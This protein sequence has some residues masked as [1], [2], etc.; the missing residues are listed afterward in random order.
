MQKFKKFS[1]GL[2]IIALVLNLTGPITAYAAAVNTATNI[3]VTPG[4]QYTTF[5]GVPVY[6]LHVTNAGDAPDSITSLTPTPLGNVDDTTISLHFYNDINNNGFADQGDTNLGASAAFASDNTKQ[7]FNIDDVVVPASGSASILITADGLTVG[8]AQIFNLSFALGTDILM[9]TVAINNTGAFP[10]Q[11]MDPLTASNTAPSLTIDDGLND[12]APKTAVASET[13][14]VVKQLSF[15]AL[16][17]SDS[18]VSLAITPS[19]SVNDATQIL[20]TKFYIDSGTT[21]GVVDVSDI[22]LSKTPTTYTADNTQTIFTFSSPF[23]IATGSTVNILYTY[24]LGAGVSGGETLTATLVGTGSTVAGS[25][26]VVTTNSSIVS[27]TITISA[28][29]PTLAQPTAVAS[30]T[31]KASSSAKVIGAFSVTETGGIIDT[32][33][34]FTIENKAALTAVSSDIASVSI[35]SDGGTLGVIDGGDALAC[36]ESTTNTTTDFDA[37]ASTITFTCSSP[38]SIGANSTNNYLAV[39][40]TTVGATNGRTI[41]A[42]VNAH[43]VTAF[44]WA[45]A[46]LQTTN[47]ITIDSV[48]PTVLIESDTPTLNKYQVANLSF[49]LSESSIDFA[50]GDITIVGGVLSDFA[51]SGTSYTAIFTPTDESTTTGTVDVSTLK[52]TDAAANDNTAATQLSM[53]IDTVAPTLVIE[54]DEPGVANIAGGDVVYTFTFSEAVTGLTI[55]DITISGGTKGVFTAVSGTVYTLVVTPNSSSTTNITVDVA[56]AV[57]IDAAGND[58]SAATQSVQ[59]VDTTITSPT[60][61]SSGGGG[62]SYSPT[63]L[64]LISILKVP[65]SLSLPSGTNYVTYYYTVWNKTS[66]QT[67]TNVSVI[68]DI[69]NKLTLVSGDSNVNEKLDPLEKWKYSCTTALSKTTTTKTTASGYSSR[70][71]KTATATATSTVFVD[72]MPVAAEITTKS[73][74]INLYHAPSFPNSGFHFGN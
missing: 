27:S 14:V 49:T 21:L 20:S 57:S 22:L 31:V 40:T 62:G 30:S 60:P 32:I 19:G 16:V 51:G 46:D 9:G 42:K 52:F 70:L 56:G 59:A 41:A 5:K 64:P 24:D 45:V 63:P 33:N 35:Y 48:A 34:Q 53:P 6:R 65:S 47:S 13:G 7:A 71:K 3:N 26:I 29:P 61:P 2:F 72:A 38:I 66:N 4:T 25:G 44:A 10:F 18:I 58:N 28:P 67:L 39:I 36:A 11:N 54:D 74:T 55:G 1:V 50:A 23:Q 12:P 73:N 8:N 68:D 43:L 17:T 69:C 37:G 15:S